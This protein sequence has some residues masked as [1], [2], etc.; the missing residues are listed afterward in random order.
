M[1]IQDTAV[2]GVDLVPEFSQ[3]ARDFYGTGGLAYPGIM[4]LSGQPL[5]GWSQY[6]MSPTMSVGNAHLF[7]R[8][9]H[10]M[11]D[12][13][14]LAERAYPLAGGVGPFMA[15]ILTTTIDGVPR[16]I[17]EGGYA[18]AADAEVETSVLTDGMGGMDGEGGAAAVDGSTV[19]TSE[20]HSL[21]WQLLGY[22][23][24]RKFSAAGLPPLGD[25]TSV[26][27]LE[28]SFKR[29]SHP[30]RLARAPGRQRCG[31]RSHGCD[32]QRPGRHHHGFRHRQGWDRPECPPQRLIRCVHV[33]NGA[34][35][36]L[37]VSIPRT[38]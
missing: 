30:L 6:S 2:E 17:R 22:S 8:R 25:H 21:I 32:D 37:Q 29:T 24:A 16:T 10:Y 7:Y 38:Q 1:T 27:Y 33:L 19:F 5:G 31:G 28:G 13:T 11:A 26:H 3:F 15:E 4:S 18:I 9:W 23:S 35:Q 14:F 12:E 34:P 20:L 36:V